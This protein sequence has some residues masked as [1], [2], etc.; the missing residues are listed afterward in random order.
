MQFVDK[1]EVHLPEDIKGL[2]IATGGGFLPIL[3]AWPCTPVDVPFSERYLA[4]EKGTVDGSFIMFGGFHSMKFYEVTK[5]LVYNMA[6]IPQATSPL[7]SS[8]AAWNDLPADIQQIFLDSIDYGMTTT[9]Q[10]NNEEEE[11]GM[12]DA[13]DHGLL[14]YECT[15]EE[16][17]VWTELLLPIR[18]EWIA[19]K[20]ADGLPGKAIVEEAERLHAQYSK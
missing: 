19:K 7:V 10:H 6:A 18:D 1:R 15:P 20:E 16:Y 2:R 3:A 5:S 14:M 13:I 11:A 4:L 12:Q 8:E 9:W 17:Q